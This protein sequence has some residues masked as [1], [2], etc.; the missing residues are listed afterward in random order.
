MPAPPESVYF[1]QI[2]DSHIGPTREFERD[3]H[4]PL[5]Y[6]ETVVELINQLPLRPDFVIHTGDIVDEPDPHSYRLAAATFS[7]LN[8]PIYYVNGNHDRSEDIR[9]FLPMGPGVESAGGPETLAYAF[10]VKGHRFLV[11]DGH[12]PEEIG[13]QGILSDA[14]LTWIREEAQPVGPPLTIFVHFPALPLDSPWMDEN[15]L[16]ING[17]AFHEALR[18]A[19]DRL[20]GVFY[21]HVHQH[22]QTLREGVLYVSAASLFIQLGAWPTDIDI[23]FYPERPPGFNFVHL[24]PAQT[25]IHQHSF[26]RPVE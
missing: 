13:P 20:R 14:Q 8:I 17:M 3:G 1:V 7:R 5:P 15:M 25:I 11:L 21:G 22:M 9:H 26:P 19:A 10:N 23:R 16:L 4:R 6:A 12:G 18:P 24:L 2:T